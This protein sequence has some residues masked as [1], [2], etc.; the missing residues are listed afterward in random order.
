MKWKKEEIT[1]LLNE[2][3][4][5]GVEYCAKKLERNNSSV[6]HK[7][8]RLN[9]TVDDDVVS[10]NKS[11]SISGKGRDKIIKENLQKKLKTDLYNINE[12]FSYV[13]G[14]LW[15]DG[16]LSKSTKFAN[17]E[18]KKRIKKINE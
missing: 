4:K 18:K 3:S 15:G 12:D 1:F 9:L 14:Y 6:Q 8:K 11:E 5:N 16:Y 2:Y 13:L 17:C 10:K 7:A